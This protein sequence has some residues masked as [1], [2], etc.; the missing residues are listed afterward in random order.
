MLIG[1][2]LEWL[3]N[4]RMVDSTPKPFVPLRTIDVSAF[5]FSFLFFLNYKLLYKNRIFGPK[6]KV[7]GLGSRWAQLRGPLK[8]LGRPNEGGIL[9]LLFLNLKMNSCKEFLPSLKVLILINEIL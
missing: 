3:V 8:I 2:T 1:S 7:A 4:L 6:V 9:Y 5:Q